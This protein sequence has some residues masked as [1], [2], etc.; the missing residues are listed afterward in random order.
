M[1]KT[2]NVKGKNKP[3]LRFKSKRQFFWRFSVL[4]KSGG[5][6]TVTDRTPDM[7][8]KEHNRIESLV[9]KRVRWELG[10][11]DYMKWDSCGVK[12]IYTLARAYGIK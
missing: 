10:S 11:E 3:E 12:D 6:I 8:V 1:M 9:N 4:K 7:D 2:K 5:V